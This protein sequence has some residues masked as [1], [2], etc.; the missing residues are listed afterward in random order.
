V[1]TYNVV[2]AYIKKIARI[3]RLPEGLLDEIMD[4]VALPY[5]A[6]L[7]LIASNK[8]PRAYSQTFK[9]KQLNYAKLNK[10]KISVAILPNKGNI[11]AQYDERNNRIEIFMPE[12]LESTKDI[13][14]SKQY[15]DKLHYLL[16]LLRKDIHHE[17]IHFI[18]FNTNKSIGGKTDMYEKYQELQ[19]DYFISPIEYK[20]QLVNEVEEFKIGNHTKDDITDFIAESVY[21]TSL[22][23]RAPKRYQKAVRDFYS[24]L[25]RNS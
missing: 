16:R 8:K 4:W 9:V 12:L 13:I 23:N 20:T 22:K 17:L 11:D 14:L 15:F 21:F 19:E 7:R 10:N 24:I 6:N 3:P 25:Y 5:T 2:A 1:N 18:Q